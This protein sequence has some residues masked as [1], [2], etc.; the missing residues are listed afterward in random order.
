MTVRLPFG[1]EFPVKKRPLC[2][3]SHVAAPR[4]PDR[5]E[6]LRQLALGLVGLVEARALDAGGQELL[7]R[8]VS[9]PAVGVV[10]PLPPAELGGARVGGGSQVRRRPPRAVVA[11]RGP[12]PA[13]RPP[14][15]L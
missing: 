11:P 5:L 6:A 1:H 13:R 14:C 9:G 15:R 4:A 2:P 12:P 10:I 3:T 8:D 7:G